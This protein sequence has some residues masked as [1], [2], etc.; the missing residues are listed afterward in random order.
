MNVQ[1]LPKSIDR[2]AELWALG[3]HNLIPIVPPDAHLSSLSSLAKRLAAGDDARGKAPGVKGWDGLWRGLDFPHYQADERDL[4]RWQGWGAG[5][6]IVCRDGLRGIDVDTTNEKLARAFAAEIEKT[7]GRLPARIGSY[8]KA[9]YPVR[10]A[11]EF[12][13]RMFEFGPAGKKRQRIEILA[14]G[15]Q[16]VAHGVHPGTHAP[17]R[18]AR[19]LVAFEDLPVV[20]ADVLAALVERLKALAPDAGP[21]A[22]SGALEIVD[23]ATLVGTPEIVERAVRL[24][25]N[26]NEAFPTRESYRDYGY[27]I[28]G[29]AGPEREA[30]GLELF[31]SWCSGWRGPNDET[32]NPDVVAADWR[33]M[34]RPLRLG[35]PRLYALA[36]AATGGAF[37]GKTLETRAKFHED[38]AEPEPSIFPDEPPEPW[39]PSLMG[40]PYDFPNPCDIEPREFLYGTHYQRE[41][42]SVTIA[43]TKVGKSSLG[44]A[45]AL[46]MTTGKPLLGVKPEGLFRVRIW[47]G[48]D[49]IK[50]LKRRIAAAM[51]HYGLT[52]E[53]VGDRLIVDSGRDQPIA[54]ARQLRDGAKVF[55][56]VVSELE[57]AIATQKIDALI[58]DPFVK[59]HSVSENDNMAIDVVVREWNRLAGATRIALELVHHSR[60]MNGASESSIDDAR[61][62]SAL[63][64]AARSARVL[65]RMN[66]R[67]SKM[68]GRTKDY[69]S[70][71]RFADAANNMAAAIA[72]EDETWFEIVSVDLRNALFDEA[73]N[74]TRKSDKVG[75]VTLS[76]TRGQAAEDAEA[77]PE[78]VDRERQAMAMLASGAW[79]ESPIA[80]DEWAG[81]AV[82]IAFDLDLTDPDQKAE[83]AA[84]LKA[85]IKQGKLTRV[86]H[87]D[88]KR[89]VRT[90]V[91]VVQPTVA[92][93]IDS[94][95]LFG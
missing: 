79:K 50:E 20:E 56:P 84:I 11:G 67:Q 81:A 60:K 8:P 85:W 16:F 90:F 27:A 7:L 22:V 28:K 53:D 13:Y 58:V 73:G 83:A 88:K 95:D 40:T 57:N 10:V 15:K 82:A 51:Q 24:T 44:I 87:A 30:W 6:G 66:E 71:F 19:P 42:A 49:P 25:P 93:K 61:G 9:L 38:I 54:I 91:E 45:E 37:D 18:W 74:M 29:A 62:A 68:L 23:Q 92:E 48:E 14:D 76:R 2:F 36:K 59:S 75:V 17:Y 72:G 21:L 26:T 77:T 65:A 31:Q 3:Y 35:A 41:Y 5:V 47:N 86:S 78:R 1:P 34:Q 32:N 52:R 12:P 39:R 33:R 4:E 69:K 64:S 94:E 70:L 80:R 55:E 89:N 63:V 46:A 43:P